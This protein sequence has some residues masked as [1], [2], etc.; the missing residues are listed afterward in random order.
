MINYIKTYFKKERLEDLVIADI[1]D[2]FSIERTESDTI[3]FKSF[4]Q[5][6]GVIH[7]LEKEKRESAILRTICGLLNSAGGILIWGSPK[8]ELLEDGSEKVFVGP[9]NMVKI[10]YEKDSFINKVSDSI[11]PTPSGVSIHKIESESEFVYVFNVQ[12]SPYS[13]HQ[14]KD[15][16][17]MRLDGQTRAAPHHYIEAL[18][19][20]ISYPK[21][22]CYI[23]PVA[24]IEHDI[25]IEFKFSILI[26]NSSKLQN[27]H[28]IS[29]RI[30]TLNGKFQGWNDPLR[31]IGVDFSNDGHELRC[32]NAKE[33]LHFGE[34]Y[35]EEFSLDIPKIKLSKNNKIELRL[36]VG[37]KSSPML[38][39]EY[40]IEAPPFQHFLTENLNDLVTVKRENKYLYE[41]QEEIGLTDSDI[42]KQYLGR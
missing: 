38:V 5:A 28:E 17:F 15:V 2:F 13:P 37:G 39:S 22:S 34:P 35:N 14:L 7:P 11:K 16:Y 32:S 33:T 6:E 19:R 1:M 30:L 4:V 9:L 18:F 26:N 21:L 24:F 8:G 12:N 10:D 36:F 25:S 31:N 3:E 42:I 20:K 27:E 41:I 23:Y 29:Y 40:V